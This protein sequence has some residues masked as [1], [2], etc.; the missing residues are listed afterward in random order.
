M[1]NS[2]DIARHKTYLAQLMHDAEIQHLSSLAQSNR[3]THHARHFNSRR[4]IIIAVLC[5]AVIMIALAL[6]QFAHAQALHDPGQLEPFAEAGTVY[7]MGFYDFVQGA[8]AEL[9]SAV[10]GIPANI[11]TISDDYALVYWGLG[12]EQVRLRLRSRE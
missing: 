5:I 10:N 12:D 9:N 1:F 7:P 6:P 2:N 3:N 4:L 8:T 11:C